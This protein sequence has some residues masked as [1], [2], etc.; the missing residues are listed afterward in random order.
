[1]P[2]LLN[3]NKTEKPL[4]KERFL[5]IERRKSMKT[6]LS[7]HHYT[8]QTLTI[9]KKAFNRLIGSIKRKVSPTQNAESQ[10]VEM[11]NPGRKKA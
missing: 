2:P 8:K 3:P 10:R 6:C 4:T 7:P 5:C 9:S 1:V 11:K